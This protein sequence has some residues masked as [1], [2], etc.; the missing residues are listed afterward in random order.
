[1]YDVLKELD[2]FFSSS[3][4]EWFV[5]D[6][7][8]ELIDGDVHVPETF[9]R[10][11]KRPDHIQSP[12]CE[13]PGSWDGLQFLCRYVYLL[14]KKLAPLT[15]SNKVFCIGDGRGP[16]KTCSES[17][18]DQCSRSSVIATGTRVNFRK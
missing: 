1:M 6:P 14:G 4:D 17:F 3:C 18:A 13:W 7:F 11:F 12:A 2:C 16:V 8:G 10:R 5:F 9:W 15:S